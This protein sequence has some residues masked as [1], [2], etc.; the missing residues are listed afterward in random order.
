MAP[1]IHPTAII[2]DGVEIGE[3]FGWM[4]G[5]RF[6]AGCSRGGGGADATLRNEG[7]VT[8]ISRPWKISAASR[9]I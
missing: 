6:A 1:R 9:A 7:S 8:T 2:E 3:D 4:A 5:R